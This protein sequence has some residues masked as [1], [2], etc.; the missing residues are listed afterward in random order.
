VRILAIDV[1]TGTQDILL[2]DTEQT[3]ENALKMVMPSPTLMVS[4]GIRQATSKR[5]SILLCGYQMGGGPS[6]WA[7]RDHALAGLPAF[8]TPEAAQTLDDDLSKVESLGIKIVSDDEV[9]NLKVDV[10]IRSGDVMLEQIL[11]AYAFFGVDAKFDVIAV[12]VFDHGKAPPDISDRKFRFDYIRKV[13]ANGEGLAG[14]AYRRDDVPQSMSRLAAVAAQLGGYT[15][16]IVMDTAPAAI[17]GALEDPTSRPDDQHSSVVVNVGNFHSLAFHIDEQGVLGLFEHHTGEISPGFLEELL[18]ELASGQLTNQKVFDSMG[19]GAEIFRIPDSGSA[20]YVVVGPQRNVLYGSDLKPYFAAP[21]GDQ[22]LV[23]CYGL[24]R[25]VAYR[26]PN[27]REE[28]VT[29]LERKEV[30][31]PDW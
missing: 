15:D 5:L 6:A 19:H 10:V 4:R 29:S 24:L 30:I 1:G 17:L 11:S 21:Y 9:K 18:V 22:M 8:A 14:F 31:Q 20:K 7:L 13:I 25:A 16:A 27:Y 12:A 23:G 2:F 28:I 26:F 3:V